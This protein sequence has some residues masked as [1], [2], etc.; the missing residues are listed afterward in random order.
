M[1]LKTRLL[2]L[3]CFVALLGVALSQQPAGDRMQR[4]RTMSSQAETRGL[5]EPFKGITT[6]GVVVPDLFPIRS[7]GVTTESARKAAGAFLASL[8]AEQRAKTVF[9]VDDPEWRKWMNQHF[10]IRQG[11]GFSEMTEAQREAAVSLMRA[12]LSAKGLKLTRDIMRLNHTLGELN[13][14]N[15]EEYGEWKYW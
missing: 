3:T 12:S 10:Y 9:P 15:F 2:A 14:N 4:F 11:V 8:T 1:E 6:N 7:T 5:A 13:N